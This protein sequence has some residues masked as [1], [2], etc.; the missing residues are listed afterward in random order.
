VSNILAYLPER[1]NML[2]KKFNNFDTSEFFSR[3]LAVEQAATKVAHLVYEKELLF[4]TKWSILLLSIQ[5][6]T[7]KNS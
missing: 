2:K 4:K 6:K 1:P 3:K 7:L 5:Q